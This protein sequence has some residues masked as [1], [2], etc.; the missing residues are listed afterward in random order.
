MSFTSGIFIS[1]VVISLIVY[2]IV[3]K[4]MQ[5]MV[6]LAASYV[7]YMAG[8][9]KT[10]I[11][12]L[13]TTL[14]TYGAGRLLGRLNE[15]RAAADK[16]A[17]DRIKKQKQHIV[18]VTLFANFGI[19]YLLKYWS[20]TA[21]Q[22]N[23][24]T[25]LQLPSVDLLLPLG[26]SFY[27]F[28]SVGYVIDCYR[29][30]YPPQQNAAKYALFSSFFPQMVQGPISRYNELAPQL[31]ASRSFDAQK[32][33]YGIQLAMW[34]YFK[35]MVIAER[36][37]VIISTVFQSPQQYGGAVLAVGVFF[38]CIQLYC[39][40]SGGIEITRGIAEMFGI[41]L[42]ENFRRPIFATSLT[43]YWRRWH[44]TLGHWMRDYVFYPLS[45]SRPFGKLGKWSRKAIGG[46]LGKILP[47]SLATFI[48]YLI[49]GIWHGGNLRY[50]FYGFW[51]GAIITSSLLLEG[52]FH[53]LRTGLHINTKSLPWRIFQICRTSL[54]VF[55][56]RY[57]TRAASLTTAFWMMA[58]LV[59]NPQLS[60]LWDGTVLTLGLS[61][62]DILVILLGQA[63]VLFVE[64]YQERGG[65]VRKA[66]ENQNIFVQ[67][68]AIA[69]PLVV[70]LMFG[71]F[72]GSY[73]PAGFIYQ[74]F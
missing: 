72:R 60:N 35:K 65:Q 7:F 74:Q 8:G 29:G 68:L 67:W 24:L 9:V 1:F 5:W 3:P 20:I 43:D 4:R 69:V 16:S 39:D 51:N 28:Q 34:G 63:V 50:I 33:K 32:V 38:Y 11:Y 30:K 10:V 66:L 19:L 22:I 27:M 6:L 13:F 37:G 15:R 53:K 61:A 54:I 57:I 17:K 41:D 44:I 59:R 49:I 64:Y 12:L 26:I 40:F 31:F 23:A 46:K 36:A 71:I 48:I 18:F 56:G 45:L 2:Y 58:Q 52:W 25:G 70:I 42:A 55:I 14:S 47:T 21:T 73:I 62:K